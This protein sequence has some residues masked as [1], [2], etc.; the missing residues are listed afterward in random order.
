MDTGFIAIQQ[1]ART[2]QHSVRGQLPSEGDLPIVPA[3]GQCQSGHLGV[4]ICGPG[5]HDRHCSSHFT[6]CRSSS[7]LR[8]RLTGN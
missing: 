1:F 6:Q 2:E 7:T 8:H 5:A 4:H 3:H